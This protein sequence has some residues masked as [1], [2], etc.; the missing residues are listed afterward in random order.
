MKIMMI[1]TTK[2][3][4]KVNKLIVFLLALNMGII[5][6]KST[7]TPERDP[8]VA[9]LSEE[10]IG[11][12]LWFQ[13]SAEMRAAY[14]QAYQYG[15]ML[16]DKKLAINTY[17]NPA[18]VFDIDETL[19]DN[20]PYQA[21]LIHRGETY[22]SAT[23]KQ[24]TD[25]ARAAA[26]PGALEFVAYARSKGLRI[27]YISNRKVSE[28]KATMQNL[29]DLGVPEV[30]DDHVLLRENASDKTERRN[31]VLESHDVVIY[32]GDNL[33]DF[34]QLFDGRGDDYGKDLVD[35]YREEL[36]NNF[37]ILPNPMYGEWERAI[38]G[39]ETGLSA[40]EQSER[41]RKALKE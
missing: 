39:N 8:M 15:R 14:Y 20:S 19:L 1:D 28:K 25:Q 11:S 6:C 41:R 16:L 32:V 2:R 7:K 12:A 9:E 27:F 33:T 40:T 4:V 37:V 36:L 30:S 23:W 3:I 26:L 35:Q 10:G 29:R 38:L 21:W 34:R 31:I 22:S 17:R 5:S 24:W 13:T 18:I